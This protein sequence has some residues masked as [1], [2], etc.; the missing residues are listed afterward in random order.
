MHGNDGVERQSSQ[1][2]ERSG[3]WCAGNLAGRYLASKGPHDEYLELHLAQGRFTGRHLPRLDRS[4]DVS[5]RR[6][7]G[8][9]GL[10]ILR[11][12]SAPRAAP[13]VDRRDWLAGLVAL[14][15]PGLPQLR[16][17]HDADRARPAA[18]APSEQ[19]GTTTVAVALASRAEPGRPPALE[20]SAPWLP[21]AAA[22]LERACFKEAERLAHL[23]QG[24]GEPEAAEFLQALAAI[25][26]GSK[27]V[28]RWPRDPQARLALAQAYFVADAGT[29]ALREA[30]EALRLDPSLGEAHAL[31]GLEHVYRGERDAALADWERARALAPT[32]EWQQALGR[33]IRDHP[34]GGPRSATP[35]AARAERGWRA[36]VSNLLPRVEGVWRRDRQVHEA[37]PHAAVR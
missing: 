3:A 18:T 10:A 22:A 32:G 23:A 26:R 1:R 37:R 31:V 36:V 2:I 4:A 14:L 20:A 16:F 35:P 24:A 30:T 28:R 5:I 12:S 33:A 27:L 34:L 25:R 6:F 15:Q 21:R 7:D 11:F 13:D 8:G 17:D 9:R 29:A 19:P